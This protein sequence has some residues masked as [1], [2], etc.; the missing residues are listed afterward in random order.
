MVS[1]YK[2]VGKTDFS[3]RL[4]LTA[5]GKP[6]ARARIIAKACHAIYPR[7]LFVDSGAFI[8]RSAY[9]KHDK[10]PTVAEATEVVRSHFGSCLW[11]HEQ[12]FP[13]KAVAELDLPDIYGQEVIDDWRDNYALPF[14]DQTGIPV[15]FAWHGTESVWSLLS[16]EWCHY[17]G[18]SMA[19][20]KKLI[21][22]QWG[23][24]EA[25]YTEMKDLALECYHNDVRIHGY[26]VTRTS[27]LKAV[28]FYSV[29]S[30]SWQQALHFGGA[31]AFDR[32]R[33]ELVRVDLG[34]GFVQR[35]G[36]TAAAKNLSKLQRHGCRLSLLDITGRKDA[37]GKR[38]INN[39]AIFLD[40]A[41]VFADMES[42]FTAYWRNKGINWAEQLGEGEDNWNPRHAVVAPPR[43]RVR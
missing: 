3:V 38:K 29:D 36:W 35:K 5:N 2:N 30:V 15:V 18:V 37:D 42:W 4:L 39:V 20:S 25:Y 22:E 16:E 14:Q 32:T 7:S 9:Y 34:R 26:A 13:L 19:Y 12:G 11:L 10:L 28:P 33:G 24:Q 40:Q 41:K 8:I 17:L 6:G 21:K 1:R 23:T 43:R 27:A 31:L